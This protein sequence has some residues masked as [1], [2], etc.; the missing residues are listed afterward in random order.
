[1]NMHKKTS[2]LILILFALSF[3]CLGYAQPVRV[4]MGVRPEHSS[5]E[6]KKELARS[7]QMLTPANGEVRV[8]LTQDEGWESEIAAV[9]NPHDSNN[10][11]AFVMNPLGATL[12]ATT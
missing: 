3:Q 7:P 9:A 4:Y 5:A 12:Y 11:A 6:S 1:M 2:L 8:K 10:V